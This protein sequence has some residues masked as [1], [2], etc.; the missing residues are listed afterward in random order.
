MRS[1]S[2]GVMPCLAMISGVMGNL[3]FMKRAQCNESPTKSQPKQ[4]EILAAVYKYLFD[5]LELFAKI[6]VRRNYET[7]N[8]L[9]C[10]DT[11]SFTSMGG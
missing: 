2:S 8:D 9:F 5:S 6:G 11:G 1:N 7:N 10:G 3:V 4:N